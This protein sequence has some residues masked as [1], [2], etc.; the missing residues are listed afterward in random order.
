MLALLF[1]TEIKGDMLSEVETSDE[2]EWANL[3]G[4]CEKVL[5]QPVSRRV[6]I[7]G[8]VRAVTDTNIIIIKRNERRLWSKSMA[9]EDAEATL[10]QAIQLQSE[11]FSESNR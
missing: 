5:R 8:I 10:L 7:D 3:L 11:A 6:Y 2:E 4:V 9:Y 1:T